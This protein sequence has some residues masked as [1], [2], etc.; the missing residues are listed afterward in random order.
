MLSNVFSLMDPLK[1]SSCSHY[2]E[3]TRKFFKVTYDLSRKENLFLFDGELYKLV[4]GTPMRGCALPL[5]V[6]VFIGHHE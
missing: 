6:E 4:D 3:L 1:W 2:N 5:V